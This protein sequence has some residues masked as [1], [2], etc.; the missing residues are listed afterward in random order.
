MLGDDSPDQNLFHILYDRAVLGRI[1]E[2]DSLLTEMQLGRKFASELR[3]L[4]EYGQEFLIICTEPLN[5]AEQAAYG[6]LPFEHVIQV[7]L[8]AGLDIDFFD[9]Q[10]AAAEIRCRHPYLVDPAFAIQ[11]Q[12]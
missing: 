11:R 9:P 6:I 12:P 4:I 7:G 2:I 3:Q 8:G 10:I 5:R 1:I